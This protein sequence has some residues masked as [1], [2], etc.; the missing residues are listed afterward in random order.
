M[1]KVPVCVELLVAKVNVELV[2]P[3]AGGVANDGFQEVPCATNPGGRFNAKKLTELLNPFRLCT[4][5]VKVV[6]AP[7]AIVREL[8][9][10]DTEKS[11]AKGNGK[12]APESSRG[13]DIFSKKGCLALEV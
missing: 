3:F 1:V 12:L 9:D 2:E 13:A 7:C 11:P 5:S 6:V 10:A 4:V 8:G